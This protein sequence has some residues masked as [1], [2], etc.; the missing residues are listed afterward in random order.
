[1]PFAAGR[2]VMERLSSILAAQRL[3]AGGSPR[4]AAI[5]AAR[6]VALA[7]MVVFHFAFDL[8]SLGLAALDVGGDPRWR[9]FARLIAGSFSRAFRHEPRHRARQGDAL[10]GL[11]SAPCDPRRRRPH[12]HARDLAHDAARVHLLRHPAFDCGRERDRPRLP[13]ASLAADDDRGAPG[14][15][16]PPDFVP[17]LPA[18]DAP[19]LRWL[20]LSTIT[21][22]TL[23]FEPVFPWLSPFLAGMALG[24]LALPHFT[25]SPLALLGPRDARPRP[26]H[27]LGGTP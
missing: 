1:M 8:D 20:G 11:S 12:R 17:P 19:H 22:A 3:D 25:K 26:R 16:S 7:A 5:D 23:D 4:F 21:P 18:F 27:H 14:A 15:A 9:W 24:R 6:G 13:A 10:G 2:S